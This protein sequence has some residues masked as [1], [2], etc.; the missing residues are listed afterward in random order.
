M[1]M[2]V[3][4]TKKG[5]T[6]SS[7]IGWLLSL[8]VWEAHPAYCSRSTHTYVAEGGDEQ[9][10][11]VLIQ[12]F[13]S[14]SIRYVRGRQ[15]DTYVEGRRGDNLMLPLLRQ[16]VESRFDSRGIQGHSPSEEKLQS[17][18]LRTCVEIFIHDDGT[19]QFYA[20]AKSYL[21]TPGQVLSLVAVRAKHLQHQ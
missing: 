9:S 17:R 20:S 5:L 12:S 1:K 3:R 10:S 11:N 14:K 18:P 6:N 19:P 8:D 7:N 2:K 4:K 15:E 21:S 16:R 13:I